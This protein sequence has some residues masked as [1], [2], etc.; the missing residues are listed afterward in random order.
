MCNPGIF[1]MIGSAVQA[2]GQY[3]Q[4]QA[5]NNAGKAQG[6]LLDEQAAQVLD[7]GTQEAAKI[8]KGAEAGRGAA[9]AGMAASGVQIGEGSALEVERQT[10]R[11][12]EEDA[13]MTLLNADRQA[14]SL[15]NQAR[16]VRAGGQQAQ[17]AAGYQMGGTF[18]QAAGRYNTWG[19]QPTGSSYNYRGSDLPNTLRGGR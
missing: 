9:V 11:L 19:G 5:A 18:L 12:G 10:L 7:S 15:R 17:T 4:G 8:R 3:Q 13:M 2:G 14:R 1:M 16:V 6:Q